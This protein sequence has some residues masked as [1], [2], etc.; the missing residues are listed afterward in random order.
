[1]VVAPQVVSSLSHMPVGMLRRCTTV[2]NELH[3]EDESD[4]NM[5][6]GV[7]APLQSNSA[8]TDG[9]CGDI[10]TIERERLQLLQ[11]RLLACMRGVFQMARICMGPLMVNLA[12]EYGYTAEQKGMILSAFAAGYALTQ[13]LGGLAA[14]R[15]GGKPLLL[16][17]LATSGGSLLVMPI[18]ADAGFLYLWWLL[19]LMGLTQGPTYPAQI[20]T[21]AKWATGSLRSYASALGGTG[22]TAGSLLALGLTPVLAERV[23]WRGT[24]RFFAIFTLLFGC[25]E[26]YFGESR[27]SWTEA[28]LSPSRSREKSV[29]F[30]E[31]LQRWCSVLLAPAVLVIFVAHAT[32]NF[33]RYFLM[34]WMP[35]YY[36]EVLLVSADAAGL[37]LIIP[38]LCG[39]ISSLAGASLGHKMQSRGTLSPLASRRLF[40]SVAFIG[41][42]VGL[43]IVC[44]VKR[45]GLVTLFLCLVQ[46]LAT[47]QGLGFGANYL[48]ISKYNGGLVT[49]VGNTVATCASFAAPVFASW[50]LPTDGTKG[51]EAWR[52]LFFAFATSNLVGLV[53]Y[54]PMLS[55][56]PVDV[57]K[58]AKLE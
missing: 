14:D 34:A 44:T 17:G 4:D 49:G 33:V 20:V 36:R 35:T 30:T 2:P 15:F 43:M 51:P 26:F 47:L 5:G 23:G 22:S 46:G 21:T 38:E 57:D 48:D 29:P 55:V 6:K 50:L 27:P 42:F 1:M 12:A 31:R 13:V 52:R 54:I 40:A 11:I 39:L 41:S 19:W 45:A 9:H 7:G 32:H 53:L 16:L 58:D 10:E 37:H 3:D 56:T 18:A 24:S 28:S 8:E 25:L